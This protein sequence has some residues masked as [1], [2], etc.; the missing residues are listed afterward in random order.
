MGSGRS[1]RV[2]R[3]VG[4]LTLVVAMAAVACAGDDRGGGEGDAAEGPSTTVAGVTTTSPPPPPATSRSFATTVEQPP[5]LPGYN[6][7][8]PVDLDA[9]GAP[10]P[11][12]VWANGGCVRHDATWSSMLERWAAAGFAVIAITVPAE[13]AAE[14]APASS[15]AD[16]AA[17][18]DWAEAQT[19]GAGADAGHFD[20]E[21]VVAAGNSCGGITSLDLAASDDRVRS[22]FVLSGSSVGPGATP[23]QAAAVMGEIS[24]PVGFAVGGEEDIA[25]H[26]AQQDYDALPA[27]VPGLVAGRR[28]FDHVLVS[29]DEGSLADVAEIGINWMDLTLHGSQAAL[30]ALDQNP[31]GECPPG[32]WTVTAKHLD[33]L[34]S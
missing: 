26:E 33:T 18:I 3:A 6:L 25:R 15:A 24:V 29:T 21:R 13:G 30:D 23:E 17:A 16:Q 19:T 31:C 12:V 2:R 5:D 7:Y 11:V 28:T 9:T 22:V 10:L 20:L 8:R 34:V 4:C 27:G 14:T 1:R 32:L